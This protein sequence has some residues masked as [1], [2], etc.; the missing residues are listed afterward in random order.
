VVVWLLLDAPAYVT[1]A[2][3]NASGGLDKD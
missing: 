3:I 2:R 1:A